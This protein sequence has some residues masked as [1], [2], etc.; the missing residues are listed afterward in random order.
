MT[1]DDIRRALERI[2]RDHQIADGK[3]A[4]TCGHPLPDFGDMAE[5]HREHLT[6]EL[7]DFVAEQLNE[8]LAEV[9]W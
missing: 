4:C 9:D 8:A 1:T 5:R 6:A 7:A 2:L 3:H